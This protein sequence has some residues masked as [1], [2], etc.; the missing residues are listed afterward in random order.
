MLR[1]SVLGTKNSSNEMSWAFSQVKGTLEE[2]FTEADLISCVEF[3]SDGKLLA[4][5][6]K[7]GRIVIFQ[8]ASGSRKA[9]NEYDLYCTFQS[10]EAEF[11][12]LKSLEIEEK[13][14]KISWLNS[15]KNAAHFMLTTNDKTIKLWKLSERDK[16]VE[17]VIFD[18]NGTDISYYDSAELRFP[19]YRVVEPTV[20]PNLRRVYTNAH[21]FHINSI[22]VNSDQETFISADELRINLWN[23][24]VTNESFVIVDIKPANM[25]ELTEVI[26]A[27]EFHPQHCNIFAYS[28]SKGAVK[29]CDMREAA[30]CDQYS[31]IFEEADVN[32]STFFSELISLISDLKFT[33]NGRYMVTRDYLTVKIWDLNMDKK[34]VETYYVHDYLRNRLCSLYETEYIF[35]KFELSI[36]GND[37]Y[38]MTGSYNMF[39]IV[40]RQ[41]KRDSMFEVNKDILRSRYLRPRKVTQLNESLKKKNKRDEINPD[42]IDLN[43]RIFH[44]AWHPKENIIAVASTKNLYLFNGVCGESILVQTVNEVTSKIYQCNSLHIR[45]LTEDDYQLISINS[46]EIENGLLHQQRVFTTA[47][48]GD[49]NLPRFNTVPIW[50]QSS[51]NVPIFVEICKFEPS[52]AKGI[53]LTDSTKLVIHSPHEKVEINESSQI[54]DKVDESSGTLRS[55]LGIF[56]SIL[57]PKEIS[58]NQISSTKKELTMSSSKSIPIYNN[59]SLLLRILPYNTQLESTFPYCTAFISDFHFRSS[60]D[61][62]CLAKLRQLFTVNE[63]DERKKSNNSKQIDS[64]L[65]ISALDSPED[66]FNAQFVDKLLRNQDDITESIILVIASSKCPPDSIQLNDCFRSSKEIVA[67]SYVQLISIN[68]SE[69]SQKITNFDKTDYLSVPVATQLTLCP[70]NSVPVNVTTWI[71]EIQKQF[72]DLFKCNTNKFPNFKNLFFLNNGFIIKL[73]DYYF[74]ANHVETIGFSDL[75]RLAWEKLLKTSFFVSSKTELIIKPNIPI[76]ADV[77]QILQRISKPIKQID[78]TH[79][80]DLFNDVQSSKAFGGFT[81][82]ISKCYNLIQLALQLTQ[83]TRTLINFGSNKSISSLFNSLLITGNKGS[84]KTT[85]VKRLCHKLI[86]NHFVYCRTINCSY[87]KGKRIESL[88]KLW[89]NS[90]QEAVQRQPSI[91]VFEDLDEISYHVEN[92]KGSNDLN[93]TNNE[94]VSFESVYCERVAYVFLRLIDIIHHLKSATLFSRVCIIVTAKSISKLNQIISKMCTF[95]E[96]IELLPP[97][98]S[99]RVDIIEQIILN[100]DLS[101]PNQ[102]GQL[103]PIIQFDMKQLARSTKN[104]Y[105][106]DL[107]HLID[108][109]IHNALVDVFQ[110]DEQTV[111]PKSICLNDSNVQ[112]A[113]SQFTPEHLKGHHRPI[114]SKRNLS[115]IGGLHQVK[116]IILNTI[117]LP[118]KYPKIFSQLPLKLQNSILLYGMPGTGKTMLVE[119]IAVES[120]LNFIGVKGPELLSKYIGASEQSVRD[121]FVRAQ[122]MAPCI[123]FFDEFDSL[124]PKRGHDSTGVTDRIVNQMLT[125]LDGLEEMRHDVYILAA[126]SRPDLIDLAL[127]RPGRFDR[128]VPCPLPNENDRI[129]ILRALSRKLNI[130]STSVRWE[131]VAEL[132]NHF[133]GADLQALLYTAYL[134]ACKRINPNESINEIEIVITDQDMKQSIEQTKP[135]IGEKERIKFETM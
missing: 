98:F 78:S 50:L 88:Q 64:L 117:L 13:I 9:T 41:N 122:A 21:S 35:D 113:L 112:Y 17:D 111:L 14:N 24:E 57:P 82:E 70:I 80:S 93:E 25:E 29:L 110:C 81:S 69:T 51:A 58:T 108:I 54:N 18:K 56:R 65:N 109:V 76:K 105:P 77:T 125:L 118:T 37:N 127:L 130:D 42:S 33:K 85:F 106:N 92:E 102:S 11:D 101:I 103:K 89:L 134:C 43:K 129:E 19:K 32:G 66:K 22:S 3:N 15:G 120:N 114:Q 62:Y 47:F 55:V 75:S 133:T 12:Y 74:V 5:G 26:T 115:D 45:P 124:A 40:D 128:C 95:D 36:G 2:D 60:V 135:S 123:L 68:H 100:K 46:D 49:S 87:V 10:H 8:R 131:S 67:T 16:R 84:G 79:L 96:T 119:A 4:C 104:Y 31:K 38:I 91:L 39:K 86:R 27:A 61:K 132:T 97:D 72:L 52:S 30:L 59:E 1:N 23:L 83:E 7:G 71:G 121:L 28:T 20:Q 6:D 107:N 63:K 99:Q 90:I 34:P 126:T 116:E 73:G 94:N 53:I 48:I 44:T